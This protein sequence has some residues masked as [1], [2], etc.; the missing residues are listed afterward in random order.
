MKAKRTDWLAHAYNNMAALYAKLNKADSSDLY[1]RKCMEL[2]SSI[3]EKDS[4]F[5]LNNIGVYLMKNKRRSGTSSRCWR[6][7]RWTW[8]TRISQAY[9][10][11]RGRRTPPD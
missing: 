5:I 9:T 8:Y 1:I 10:Q 11:R 7:H 4:Q 6:Q 2:M 3:P